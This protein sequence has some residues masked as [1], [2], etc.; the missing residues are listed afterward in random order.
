RHA[1]VSPEHYADHQE[2]RKLK[3]NRDAT[4]HERC[5]R[6]LSAASCEQ[7]LDDQ[8]IGAVACRNKESSPDQACP[9]CIGNPQAGPEVEH[10]QLAGACGGGMDRAP[11][12]WHK[13]QDR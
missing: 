13:V 2:Q 5:Y 8:L 10:S 4:R 1:V 11:S 12:S 9:K 3:Q 7:A 6:L